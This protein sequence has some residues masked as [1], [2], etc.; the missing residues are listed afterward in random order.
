M[1]LTRRTL[2]LNSAM[3]GAMLAA[4]GILRAQGTRQIKLSHYLPPMHQTHLELVRWADEL[5]ATSSGALDIQLFPAG[6][7]GPPPRQADLV[8]TGVADI[9]FVYTAL[10]PGRFPVND[11]FAA[12]FVF[13][14]ADGEPASAA[15]ASWVATSM[16]AQIEPEFVDC[17]HLY[18][19]LTTNIGFFMKSADIRKPEDLRGL[20]IR[21]G[22]STVADQITAMGASPANVG[23]AELADAIGK[24]VVDGAMFNFEGGKAFQLQQSVRKVSMISMTAGVFALVANKAMMDELPAE[25][26]ALIRNTT[27]PEAARRVGGL[28]DAAEAAGREAMVADGVEVVDLRGDAVKPFQEALAPVRAAQLDALRAAGHD[29][30]ALLAEIARLL[31]E[32]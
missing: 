5:R 10:N 19:V 7:M 14:G 11:I 8:R 30:D 9:A 31:A 12:P 23:P 17:E 24:G 32:A 20:R 4:P 27:G 16:R 28:Y 13:T 1:T 22:S 6:Q 21:P 29:P 3:A 2:F 25:L 26:A 18:S 15:K